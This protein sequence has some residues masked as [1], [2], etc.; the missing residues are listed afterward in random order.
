MTPR[1]AFL[2]FYGRHGISPVH[3]DISNLERH[4][5][6]RGNL[7]RMLG[8]PPLVF[9][10]SS[11]LEVGPGGGY[12]AFALLGWEP[13]R[14]VLVEPN[15]KGAEELRHLF[16]QMPA[17]RWTLHTDSIETADLG[18]ERF[19]IVICEGM[20]PGLEHQ[21][22]VLERLSEATAPGGLLVVT[23]VDELSLLFERLRRHMGNVLANRYGATTLAERLPLLTRAFAS[24]FATLPGSRR[25]VED[26]ATDNLINPA[27]NDRLFS[28]LDCLESLGDRFTF[29]AATPDFVTDYRWY[30]ATPPG[31][32]I[33]R[34]QLV[35]AEFEALRHNFMHYRFQMAPRDPTD[36]IALLA[37]CEA[38]RAATITFEAGDHTAAEAVR[39]QL[40][41]AIVRAAEAFS[42]EVAAA[43]SAA[44]A[45]LN[46]SD[47]TPEAIAT[48]SG[49][50]TEAY[51][52]GQQYVSLYRSA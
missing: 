47:L 15:P 13:R 12:N 51:G 4:V 40:L 14:L 21:E 25:P 32:D 41:P 7:Y 27:I 6:V 34:N 48:E 22:P 20:I 33:E 28:V 16:A 30:K 23:C 17:E 10:A 11:I 8:M 3:Q 24:H 29:H 26:W 52:R 38:L 37:Q 45:L 43:L 1:N 2:E 19:D 31:H 42:S 18:A 50:F 39:A 9:R 35:R 5:A 46:R 49:P 44:L 36:N